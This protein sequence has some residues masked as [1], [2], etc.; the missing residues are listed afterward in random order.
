M[1]RMR[2]LWQVA[3]RE[4]RE[5][6]RSKAYLI[7]STLT[8]LIVAGIVVIP[9][10]LDGGTDEINIGSVGDGNDVIIDTAEQLG[11]ANDEPGEPASVEYVIVG[12]QNRADAEAGL[13]AGDVDAVLVDGGE[14]IVESNTGIGGNSTVNAL[15]RAA[16]TVEIEMVV[17]RRDLA[18]G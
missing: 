16:A 5:R 13:E 14:V 9:A 17:A 7:A 2:P 3:A 8:L 15:Q 12:Y 11:T 1:S 18:R 10:L 4:I 6:G